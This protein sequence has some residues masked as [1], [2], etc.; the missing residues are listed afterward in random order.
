MK[1]YI[2]LALAGAVCVLFGCSHQEKKQ[3]SRSVLRVATCV[4]APQATSATARYVGTIEPIRETP[5]SMQSTGRVLSIAYKDGDRVRKGQVILRIDTTQAAN[6]LHSAQAALRQAQDGYDRVK[7][8]Y[9]KGAVT[10]QKMVEIE[11][12]LARARSLEAAARQQ[13]KECKLVAPCE[14]VV[15]GLDIQV[16]QM[17]IPGAKLCALLDVSAYSVRFTVP[18]TEVGRIH[19]GERG[20]VECAAVGDTFPI[21]MTEKSLKANPVAHTYEVT[22]RIEGNTGAL[23]AG[24]IGKVRVNEERLSE[25]SEQEMGSIVI[26]AS[27][28]LLKPSGPTVWVKEH[29]EAVRRA[30]TIAGYQADGVRVEDGLH[31]GDSL[32]IEGYQKL[33]TGC[34]VESL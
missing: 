28:I 31:A 14:G 15:S 18:E 24:M 29:G 1:R 3:Q 4:I 33:Y 32:I 9:G 11:S 23:L 16:G 5:L 2:W 22:A 34:K 21:V 20:A 6:A 27:C 26:P 19:I 25:D 13:M 30:I 10:D 17:V 7:Q 8:V 12:Q